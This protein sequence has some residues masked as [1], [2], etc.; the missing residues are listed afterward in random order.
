MAPA[1]TNLLLPGLVASC[2]EVL[3]PILPRQVL[4]KAPDLLLLREAAGPV[5]CGS[6]GSVVA[7]SGPRGLR[8]LG[9]DIIG[10]L[11]AMASSIA[12]KFMPGAPGATG[13]TTR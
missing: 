11:S 7:F 1:Q 4:S 9:F 13:G 5:R 3:S 12:W 2:S 6:V 10:S 8:L